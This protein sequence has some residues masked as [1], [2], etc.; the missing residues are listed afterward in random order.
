MRVRARVISKLFL[1]KKRRS[2]QLVKSFYQIA[3]FILLL[4][5]GVARA[6]DPA[7]SVIAGATVINIYTGSK[8]VQDIVIAGNRISQVGPLGTV[9]V[10]PGARIINATGKYVIP[11]LWDSHI[12]LT[13]F[14]ELQESL[15]TLLVAYGITSVRD[16]GAPL[17]KIVALRDWILQEDVIAPHIYFAGPLINSSPR[18][19]NKK[20]VEVDTPAQAIAL[21]DK[22][23]GAG[24]SLVKPYEMLKPDI[25]RAV[26]KRAQERGLKVAGHLPISMSIRE[27]LDVLPTYDIQHLGGQISGVKVE[28]AEQG[29]AIHTTRTTYLA[30]HRSEAQKGVHLMLEV[31]EVAP[32]T[33][34]DMNASKRNE[35]IHLFAEKGTW[36]TPTLTAL[37]NSPQLKN[38]P[39]R[40]EGLQYLPKD[41]LER[42]RRLL[43]TKEMREV[44]QRRSQ[45]NEWNLETVSLIHEADIP[46]LAGTDT[47]PTLLFAP[48]VALHFEL[49]ALVQAGLSP[50]EALQTATLN[51]AR[52]F[53]IEEK[54]GS[55]TEGKVADMLLLNADPLEDITNTH[56]INTVII[57]GH[58]LDREELD[59]LLRKMSNPS[60]E[61]K[62]GPVKSD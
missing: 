58:V 25:F 7:K 10:P 18:W 59:G 21:V 22:L 15:P 51:P 6:E 62:V 3:L 29:E 44:V 42:N 47:P 52:F 12:H 30:D 39:Y 23:A 35:L 17:E 27:V 4:G 14:P 1:E 53:D 37:P 9:P 32:V 40:L 38:H 2:M 54:V 43:E 16:M 31:E 8:M 28:S 11:G 13:T 61:K 41:V 50:L 36:H 56:E 55:I 20:S 46:M 49:E 26:V 33:L 57:G 24:A 48:G 5:F 19:G 45:W 60:E 34:T